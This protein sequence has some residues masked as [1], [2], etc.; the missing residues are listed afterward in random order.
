MKG[1]VDTFF[2]VDSMQHVAHLCHQL[3]QAGQC[4]DI[5][6]VVLSPGCASFDRFE[7]FEDRGRKF[8]HAVRDKS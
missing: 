8:M 4:T 7:N 3:T 1:S 6:T 5:K 2:S